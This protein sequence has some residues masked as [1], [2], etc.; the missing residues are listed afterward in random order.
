MFFEK[1]QNLFKK[2]MEPPQNIY[3]ALS[4]ALFGC[5]LFTN[6]FNIFP[7]LCLKHCL[8]HIISLTKENQ[9][10]HKPM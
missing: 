5:L 2:N 6:S 4:K 10:I 1:R 9:P 7:D 3:F 8:Y